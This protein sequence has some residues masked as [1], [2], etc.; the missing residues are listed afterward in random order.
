MRRL[1]DRIPLHGRFVN[2]DQKSERR[3]TTLFGAMQVPFQFG[4]AVDG[5]NDCN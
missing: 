1:S 3:F 4:N 5:M 2:L